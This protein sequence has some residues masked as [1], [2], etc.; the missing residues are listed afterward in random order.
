MFLNAETEVTGGGEVALTQFVFLYFQSTLKD[1]FSLGS[2]NGDMAGNFF[3][4][5]DTERSDGVSG[6]KIMSTLLVYITYFL[7]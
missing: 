6:C 5:S 1:F 4:S 7:K 2:T 3:V